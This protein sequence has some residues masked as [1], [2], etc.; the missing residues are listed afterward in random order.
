MKNRMF[1]G[2]VAAATALVLSSSLAGA[3]DTAA[4][5]ANAI[6][7]IKKTLPAKS[8][9]LVSIPLNESSGGEWVFSQTPFFDLPNNSAVMIW[10]VTNATWISQTKQSR[11]G[12]SSFSNTVIHPGQPLFVYNYATTNIPVIFSGEVPDDASFSIGIP[13]KGYQ[14]LAN[15]YPVAMTWGDTT[16][17]ANAANNSAVML[18][19]AENNTWRSQTKQARGGWS[20][21][22][23][24]VISPADGI[25]FYEYANDG[26]L[27][28]VEKPYTWPN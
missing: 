7:V 3:D 28:T 27:W 1:V 25:F 21:F 18:W 9:S 20:T 6:G 19:D 11:G 13:G 23:T 26:Y 22:V 12:W 2:L 24:N 15:P 16:L 10:D 14:L 17:A 5:S 4:Y 8:Y